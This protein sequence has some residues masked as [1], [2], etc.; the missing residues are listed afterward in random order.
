MTMSPTQAGPIINIF[1]VVAGVGG[2]GEVGTL[3]PASR[4]LSV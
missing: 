3:V 1:M 4:W 2:E